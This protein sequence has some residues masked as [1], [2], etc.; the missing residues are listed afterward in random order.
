MTSRLGRVMTYGDMKPTM[1]AHDLWLLSLVRSRKKIKTQYLVFCKFHS[2][3]AWQSVS[4][5]CR[6]PTHKTTWSL[7]YLV[8]RKIK[9]KK[10]IKNCS[11]F[12]KNCNNRLLEGII[13]CVFSPKIRKLFFFNNHWWL[14][15]YEDSLD[16]KTLLF[17][18]FMYFFSFILLFIFKPAIN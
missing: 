7:N 9:K 4:W 10:K 8:T 16:E 1:E 6:C 13:F 3:Q 2:P 11:V 15:C 5:G 17:L 14:Y 12:N 18:R